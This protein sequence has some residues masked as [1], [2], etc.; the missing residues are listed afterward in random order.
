[1]GQTEGKGGIS[2]Q[3]SKNLVTFLN[4]KLEDTNRIDIYLKLADY[5]LRKDAGEK[6]DL[7]SA[8]TF[9]R[10]AKEINARQ[11]SRKRDGIITYYEGYQLRKAGNLSGAIQLLNVAAEQLKTAN[12]EFHLALAWLE[13]SRCY[14]PHLPGQESI[15]KNIFNEL[16]QH[17]PKLISHSQMN[18]CVSELKNFYSFKMAG[19][20]HPMKLNFLE[21][22]VGAFKVINDKVN[23]LWV[24]KELADIHYQDGKLDLA[25]NELLEVAKEQKTG[26]YPGICFTYDLLSGFYFAR[27]NYEKALQY[28]LESIKNVRS[29]LDSAYLLAFYAR[30][31]F[32]YSATG[33]IAEAIQWNYKSLNSMIATGQTESLYTIVFF[34]ASDMVDLGQPQKGLDLI[35]SKKRSIAPYNLLE[36]RNMLS[37]LIQCYSALH[38]K[39]MVDK[40]CEELID[41]TNQRVKLKEIDNDLTSDRIVASAYLD[42]GELSKAEKYFTKAMNEMPKDANMKFKLEF[43]FELDSAKGNYVSAIKN[44]RALQKLNDSVSSAAKTRQIEELKINYQTE[45]KDQVINLKEQNIQLLTKQD[46]LQRSQLSQ[47][48][49]I[50]NISF[51]AVALLIIVMALLFNRYRLRQRANRKLELQQKEI[52]SQNISLQHLV[53]EK[54]WLV[55]EIH[56]RVKNNLQTVMGLLGTQSGYLKNQEAITAIADSQHRIQ[57]MSLIHQ[58]L[59]QSNNLSAIKMADYI[60]ELVD[61]LSESFNVGQRIRFNLEIDPLNLDLAHCI[62]LGL[63]IN[64]AITNSFKYAFPAGHEGVIRISLSQSFE[65]NFLLKIKDNG[66]GLPPDFD[67]NQSD[68]MGMNL[69]Q[70]L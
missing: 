45:Q 44:L 14:D 26:G 46:Q 28:S 66:K 63:I 23:E 48:S 55:K 35:L 68:S 27:A 62:P 36:K 16:F 10:N 19:D 43:G 60:H 34:I 30:I 5:H 7:D 42:A 29:A 38:N 31:A 41:L 11:E 52:F 53:K 70:G 54:D 58:R 33:S 20:D 24:R 64:E 61:S 12:D 65:N 69:M 1:H 47:A 15:I 32:D 9:I 13:L 59:Y 67:L 40:Y 4:K 6:P 22:L 37:G 57:S 17:V 3:E 49:I 39:A 21:H 8:A 56:H 25:T 18:N 50:R 2:D 51:S